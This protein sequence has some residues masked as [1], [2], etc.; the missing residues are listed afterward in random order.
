MCCEGTYPHYEG[1][2][3]VWCDQLVQ[4]MPEVDFRLFS[5]THTP[6][7]NPV[8]PIRENVNGIYDVTLWGNQEPGCQAGSFFVTY[9]RKAKTTSTVI[10]KA[11][12]NPFREM[13]RCIFDP[14][15]APERLGNALLQLH[16]YF[17][18]FDY[19]KSMASPEAWE[20]F[21]QIC[22]ESA[23]ARE[24][25][26]IHDATTCMRWLQRYLGILTARLP[27]TDL[28]HSAIAGLA[29]IP[30]VLNKLL[31]RTPFLLTEHGIYLRE[32][33][34]WLGKCGYSYAC[35]RFLLSFNTAIVKV[36]YHYADRVTALGTFNK[37]WQVRLG[38]Q[39]RKIRLTPNGS[40]PNLFR[41]VPRPAGDRTVVLTMARIYQIKGIE[42]LL[43]AAAIVLPKVPSVLFRV[44]GEPADPEYFNKCR[45]IVAEN[46]IQEGVEFGST[47]NPAG[48]YADA[49][50]FCLPSISEGMPYSVLEAM[51]SGRAVVATDVGNMSEVLAGTG[52]VVPPADPESLARALL[53]LLEGDGAREYRESLAA[54]AL[55]RA[56]S[57]YTIDQAIDRFRDMYQSLTNDRSTL[58]VPAAAW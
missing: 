9:R 12:L 53:S 2:V 37:E 45:H 13:V 17:R 46:G 36:N 1:G 16:L 39:E 11:F 32:L 49:D 47:K 18:H 23:F 7:L 10:R 29:S 22:E 42:F 20:S 52:I 38:V 4:A 50:M 8:F 26:T 19:S 15:A 43:R 5:V 55:K 58:E 25:F 48:A 27:R 34:L 54:S 56:Q 14:D 6:H 44:L 31:Y 28:T 3:S 24:E 40:D 33:Y 35:R 57:L 41:P 51:F 21:L 30:G